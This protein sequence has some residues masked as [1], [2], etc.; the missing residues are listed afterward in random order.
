MNRDESA[1]VVVV[2]TTLPNGA[3]PVAFSTI[4]VEERLAA[5][6]TVARD[7]TSVYRWKDVVEEGVEH[8]LTIKTTAGR[9][10]RLRERFANL[11]P[12]DLPEFLVLEAKGSRSYLSWI[13]ESTVSREKK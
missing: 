2:W 12:Y 5:C 6:V 9:L 7:V 10:E 4:L 1:E 11:H 3:D 8:H 13:S